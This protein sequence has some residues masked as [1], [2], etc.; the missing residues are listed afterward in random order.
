MSVCVV[1]LVALKVV[2]HKHCTES[3]EMP[4]A[5]APLS[6]LS[7]TSTASTASTFTFEADKEENN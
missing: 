2:A 4:R 7:I 5:V 1:E 3:T 6:H